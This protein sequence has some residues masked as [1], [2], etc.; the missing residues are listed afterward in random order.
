MQ[1]GDPT[2]VHCKNNIQ[3]TIEKV[4]SSQF[5]VLDNFF[6]GQRTYFMCIYSAPRC[7][8][9][10]DV[11]TWIVFLQLYLFQVTDYWRAYDTISRQLG[12]RWLKTTQTTS[13]VFV[14][15]TNVLITPK[16]S[17]MV[18]IYD[19]NVNMYI[20]SIMNDSDA[21]INVRQIV[22]ICSSTRKLL[23]YNLYYHKYFCSQRI[24]SK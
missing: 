15:G 4:N 17:K 13:D 19:E 7:A 9:I 24:S 5:L 20:L 8:T 14:L 21:N 2:R 11:F 16:S 3:N 6:T 22:G 18:S 12:L 10:V 1:L 23:Q